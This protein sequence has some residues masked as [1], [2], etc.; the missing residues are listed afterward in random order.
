MTDLHVMLAVIK[1]QRL[2]RQKVLKN[3]LKND[4]DASQD[5]IDMLMKDLKT[6][7]SLYDNYNIGMNVF[8]TAKGGR[9]KIKD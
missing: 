1:C 8:R 5:E 7:D 9:D 4:P 6:L 2:W 3:R